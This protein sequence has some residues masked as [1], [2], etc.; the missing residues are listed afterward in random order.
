MLLTNIARYVRSA[1]TR[2]QDSGNRE[3]GPGRW[4][5]PSYRQAPFAEDSSQNQESVSLWQRILDKSGRIGTVTA[6]AGCASCFPALGALA[7]G[8]GLGFLA[9]FEEIFVDTLMPIFAGVALGANVL[10][11]FSHRIW[12]RLVAG[13]AGPAIVLATRY[14]F[15]TYDW[16]NYVFYAGLVVMLAVAVWDIVSPPRK[17][18]SSCEVPAGAA[19]C[20]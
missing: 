4:Q 7:A 20:V 12:Y 9:Q 3:Q 8:L 17:V 16:R 5:G 10:S 19:P 6:A 13:I 2:R 15:W 14:L 1:L 18:C 11:F